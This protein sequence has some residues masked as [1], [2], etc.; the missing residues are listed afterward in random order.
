MDL[1][2]RMDGANSESDLARHTSRRD[3]VRA[4]VLQGIKLMMFYSQK[5][6]SSLIAG[7]I[8]RKIVG[9]VGVCVY[10]P[11]APIH[12]RMQFTVVPSDQPSH[13]EGCDA[14]VI[15]CS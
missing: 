5:R 7:S 14:P 8:I 3:L 1:T 15:A 13:F 6:V 2:W 11:A 12:T 10:L 9:F 4:L